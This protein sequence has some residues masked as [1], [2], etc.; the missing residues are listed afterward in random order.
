MSATV[1]NGISGRRQICN[2]NLLINRLT[3]KVFLNFEW[4][5]SVLIFCVEYTSF[6][7]REKSNPTE[8]HVQRFNYK[9]S[10]THCFQ[11][12]QTRLLSF[13]HDTHLNHNKLP[14]H[15]VLRP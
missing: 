4:K 1:L 15:S 6:N 9:I 10:R 13:P 12:D 3:E 2:A 8:G 14:V 11:T 5:I 7:K